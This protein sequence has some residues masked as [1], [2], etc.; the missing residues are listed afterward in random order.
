[1]GLFKEGRFSKKNL[2][3]IGI[4]KNY[5]VCSVNIERES[6]R[7]REDNKRDLY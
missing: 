5:F 4:Q 6:K 3:L 1:M 2:K 7:N